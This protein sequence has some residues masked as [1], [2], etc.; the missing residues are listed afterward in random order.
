MPLDIVTVPC[1]ADNYAYLI[2]DEA[3]G[4]VAVADVPEAGPILKALGERG[5]QLDQILITHHHYDHIDGVDEVRKA[6]GAKVVGYAADAGRLP[7]LDVALDDGE[8]HQLGEETCEVID[9]SGHTIGHIAYVFHDALAAF[10]GDSLMAWGCGR[11][12]E[13]TMEMMWGSL[14][15]F[16]ALPR[17]MQIYS[18]HEYTASNAKFA[19]TIEPDNPSLHERAAAVTQ[20]R[21]KG[22]YT[23]PSGLGLELATN[24]FLRAGHV[25]VKTALGMTN[26]TD[27]EV[28]AEIRTRKDNF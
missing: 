24:P 20:A 11:V 14:S 4:K 28:F 27:A 15:K 10:T 1:L 8:T 5:W 13:G 23:V 7:P 22:E 3:T 19:V 12:F 21:A 6:T 2:R 16:H 9:V 25:K 17:A 26:A 18:G